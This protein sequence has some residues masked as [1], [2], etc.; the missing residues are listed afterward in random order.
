LFIAFFTFIANSLD[1]IE[2]DKVNHPERPLPAHQLTSTFA[3]IL[4]FIALFCA[5]F[6]IRY[7]VPERVAFWYYG[8][9]AMSISYRYVVA[10]LP[11]LKAFY[12]AATASILPLMIAA[13]Y[14]NKERL[15]FVAGA[16]F[17]LVAGK[18]MCMDIKDRPGDPLSFMHKFHAKQLAVVAFSLETLGLL[19]LLTQVRKSADLIDMLAMAFVLVLSSLHWFRLASYKRAIILMEFQLIFG[20]YFLV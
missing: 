19:L 5:L 20:I 13:W 9:T 17:L 7:Y 6:L 12:V 16:T 3:A 8:L 2:K 4:Y 18:E 10:C 11:G 1:D 15:Y 14:P